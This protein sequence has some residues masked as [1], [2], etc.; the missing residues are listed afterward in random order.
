[1]RKGRTSFS[2]VYPSVMAFLSGATLAFEW[3]EKINT[4]VLIFAG[5]TLLCY[6]TFGIVAMRREKPFDAE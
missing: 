3:T 5:L 6:L 1:M 2:P 4:F